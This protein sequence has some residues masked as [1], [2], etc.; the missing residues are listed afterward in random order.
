MDI[1][2]LN[3]EFEKIGIIDTY[4]S[5]IW[6]DRYDEYGDFEIV[7]P[8]D[9]SVLTMIKEDYYLMIDKSE[10][11]MIIE[12]LYITTDVEDGKRL[13]VTGCSL[14]KLLERRIVWNKT[15]FKRTYA[16]DTDTVGTIPSLQNGVKKLLDENII[17]PEIAARRISNFIFE[18]STNT[19]IT[20]LTLEAEYRGEN[21]YEIIS[22]LC[23]KNKI[24]FKI[25]LN[26]S[27]QLVFEL[28]KGSNRTYDQ[29]ENPY[30]VFSPSNDNLLNS[31]YCKTKSSF[32]NVT[33]V[34]GEEPENENE[35][36]TT[37]VIGN[38][39][40]LNRREIFTN[41]SDVSTKDGDTALTDE[42]YRANLK[43]RGI[44]TL[45]DNIEV[46]AF[47]GELE[48]TIIYQ[49]GEDFFMGDIVQLED[50]YGHEGQAYISEFIISQD[51][52]GISMY[53]T[54]ISLQEGD[55]NIYE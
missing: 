18:E 9:T 8:I 39:I 28:Y 55:Y 29:L 11:V 50:E 33:L 42:Q 47:D 35:Q 5:M 12:D 41:A 49:Y 24:G 25:V 40:G 43:Q 52:S 10:H 54:F 6:T 48:T 46:E 53:P 13:K 30:I 37:I 4:I 51:A 20:S 38:E 23:K 3:T 14:E 26:S 22:S 19:T 27:N 16:S 7:L 17:S 2:V 45:I 21:L 15:I 32:K 44:D 31:K 36:Q 1:L 34:A